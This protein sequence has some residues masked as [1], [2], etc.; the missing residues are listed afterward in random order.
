MKEVK[1]NEFITIGSSVY[2][3]VEGYKTDESY[4][5][6]CDLDNTHGCREVFCSPCIEIFI[7]TEVIFTLYD[8]IPDEELDYEIPS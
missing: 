5:A 2:K 3:C 7:E 4:C 1:L 8:T 6:N